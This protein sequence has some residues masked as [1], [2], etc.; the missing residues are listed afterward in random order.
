M[1]TLSRENAH[2]VPATSWNAG[3]AQTS[4][5]VEV[6]THRLSN[7][8]SLSGSPRFAPENVKPCRSA[9]CCTA[10]R[11]LWIALWLSDGDADAL[12]L[13]HERD[14]HPGALP[15]LPGAGRPLDEEVALPEREHRSHGIEVE[16]HVAARAARGR[17]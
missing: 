16:S 5:S 17:R 15:G 11:K 8:V 7:A 4:V 9:S 14:R 6:T 10:R 12:S 3:S 1:S 13:P 2:A